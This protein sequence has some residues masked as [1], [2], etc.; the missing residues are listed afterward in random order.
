VPN[1]IE[2]MKR[3]WREVDKRIAKYGELSQDEIQAEIERYRAEK[4]ARSKGA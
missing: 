3:I 1:P 2:E 4:R